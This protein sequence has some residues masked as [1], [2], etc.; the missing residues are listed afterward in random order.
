MSDDLSAT[1]IEDSYRLSPYATLSPISR[2]SSGGDSGVSIADDGISEGE[3][4][5]VSY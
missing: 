2:K 1:H 5:R 4:S 3:L